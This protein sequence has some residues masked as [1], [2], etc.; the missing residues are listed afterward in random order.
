M[1]RKY[2]TKKQFYDEAVKPY[3]TEDKSRNRQMFNDTKDLY[4]RDGLISYEKSKYWNY[5][6]TKKFK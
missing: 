3:L 1:A 5:P 6:S 2:L 4:E